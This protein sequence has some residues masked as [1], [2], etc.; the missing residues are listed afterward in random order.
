MEVAFTPALP[1]DVV[2]KPGIGFLQ[3]GGLIVHTGWSRPLDAAPHV[4]EQHPAY[5]GYS[6]QPWLISTPDGHRAATFSYQTLPDAEAAAARIAAA[7]P[8]GMWPTDADTASLVLVAREASSGP[9]M[10]PLAKKG[11]PFWGSGLGGDTASFYMPDSRAAYERMI[12][13]HGR[14]PKAC[15]ACART[16][17]HQKKAGWLPATNHWPTWRVHGGRPEHYVKPH[18]YCGVCM[19]MYWRI[20][21]LK[22]AVDDAGT[23]EVL[24]LAVYPFSEW[25]EVTSGAERDQRPFVWFAYFLQDAGCVVL[26]ERDCEGLWPRGVP[27]D[28]ALFCETGQTEFGDGAQEA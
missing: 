3:P 11:K 25:G 26:D 16:V 17:R 7:L 2:A 5:E 8:G 6:A 27:H 10:L 1:E 20:G 12:A 22:K 9:A 24:S 18:C 21:A 19:R 15:E 28:D 23:T 13:A 14:I 4:R